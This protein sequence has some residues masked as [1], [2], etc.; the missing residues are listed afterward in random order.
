MAMAMD[1]VM[2]K[3]TIRLHNMGMD[4][5]RRLNPAEFKGLGS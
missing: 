3:T 5:R 4:H 1:T 2:G